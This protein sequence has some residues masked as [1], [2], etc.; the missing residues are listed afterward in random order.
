MA[1]QLVAKGNNEDAQAIFDQLAHSDFSNLKILKQFGALA[2]Q[3]NEIIVAIN[4]LS[5]VVEMEPEDAG[6]LDMLASALINNGDFEAAKKLL[7]AA[8]ELQPDLPEPYSRLGAIAVNQTDYTESVRI[9]EKGLQLKPRDP[10]IILNIVLSLRHTDRHEDALKYARKLIRLDPK[11]P[12]SY[13]MLARVLTDLGESEEA[14]THLG[15]AI[16]LDKTHGPSYNLLSNI[17]KF[18]EKDSDFI[19]QCENTLTLSMPSDQRGLIHF[20]LGKIYDDCKEWDKAFEHYRKGNLLKKF[21]I[22]QDKTVLGGLRKIC[23]SYNEKLF[24]QASGLGSES[25]HP[26]FVV[27]MPRSGTT[28]I[29]QIIFSHPEGAGA[30]EL[31]E[32]G[33]IDK[34]ICPADTRSNY[35]KQLHKNLRKDIIRMHVESYLE[36]LR[37]N[38]QH[39]KRIV[40]KMPD[41]FINLGL[42]NVLFPNAHIIHAIRNPLDTCLSCYFRHFTFLYWSFDMKRIATRYRFYRETMDYWKKTLPKGKI[43]D[44]DYD[45]LIEDPVNQTRRIIES[46]GLP[47]DERCLEFY[48]NKRAV[49]T[50][51]VWQ[52]RQPIHTSSNRRWTHYVQHLGDIVN[53]LSDYLGPED[54]EEL[55]DHGIE[56]SKYKNYLRKIFTK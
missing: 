14:I 8:I 16:G 31:R 22:D 52:V 4:I 37:N 55:K 28:L 11:N 10:F 3:L 23:K 32:I 21:A 36:V 35:R 49:I 20:S 15:K 27:G 1:S 12:D 41:N 6:A 19:K 29:E 54:I 46:I 26:V 7:Y 40:D 38:R 53:E 44:V 24:E 5:R 50:E 25:D 34:K 2:L 30:G 45:R 33:Q 39:A 43:I 13:E 51:S 18:S 17:K 42:I 9:L 56:V 47:W 48:K